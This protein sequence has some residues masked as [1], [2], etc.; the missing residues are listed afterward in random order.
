MAM[1]VGACGELI[2]VALIHALCEDGIPGYERNP[3]SRRW[4]ILRR[5]RIG[6]RLYGDMCTIGSWARHRCVWP[7]V[8]PGPL[9]S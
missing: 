2:Y 6:A 7:Q 8:D 9:R 5:E 3:V 1:L 4:W